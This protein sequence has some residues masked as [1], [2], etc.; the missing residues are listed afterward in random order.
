MQSILGICVAGT[1]RQQEPQQTILYFPQKYS[2]SYQELLE[3]SDPDQQKE[4][5]ALLYV[6]YGKGEYIYCALSL[7]RQ[8]KDLHPGACRLFAN[9]ISR[10]KSKD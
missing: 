1:S 9:L 7:W 10:Q 2:S 5:G 4:K 8:L 3:L 6:R